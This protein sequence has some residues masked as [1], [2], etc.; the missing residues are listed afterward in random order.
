[1][2]AMILAAGLGTRLK[3][4]TDSI[5]KALI[6]IGGVPLLEITIQKLISAG[7]DEI[8]INIHHF[9]QQIID[10]VES[11]N[12]F[13]IQIEFSN[14]EGKLLDTGGALK[15]ATWFFK[16]NKP[17]LVHNVD[18]LSNVDLRKLYA[19]HLYNDAITTLMVSDR[20]TTRYFLFDKENHL[21]GWV[22][23]KT[24][25][26]KPHDIIINPNH[27]Q[28]LAFS[29]VQVI[30]PSIFKYMETFPE[31]F[32]IVDFYLSICTREKLI[33]YIP[34]NLKLMDAGKIDTLNEAEEF[35]IKYLS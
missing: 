12:K 26:T 20:I 9:G 13:G 15:K 8:I 1:M 27:Y 18:I 5:P 32:S 29:G 23:N 10:F 21:K 4:L 31:M 6:P 28:Q 11:K 2:K 14:E 7:F 35:A 16:D 30:N 25:E 33:G 3:P 34:E 22:N 24:G 17:F 19:T